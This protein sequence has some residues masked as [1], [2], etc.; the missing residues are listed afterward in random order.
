MIIL[1]RLFI[2]II[3]VICISAS[4]YAEQTEEQKRAQEMAITMTKARAGDAQAQYEV[5]NYYRKGVIPGIFETPDNKEAARWYSKSAFGGSAD[6]MVAYAGCLIQGYLEHNPKEAVKWYEKA[7]KKGNS[8]AYYNLGVCYDKGIGVSTDYTKAFEYFKKAAETGI[9]QAVNSLAICYY[10]G[11]GVAKNTT[12]AFRLFKVSAEGGNPAGFANLGRCYMFGQG[13][14]INPH[15]GV[16]WYEKAA[17]AGYADCQFFLGQLFYKGA[18]E[19]CEGVS[20]NTDYMK[21]AHYLEMAVDNPN[22]PDYAKAET[23]SL[24][25]KCYRLGRGVERDEHKADALNEQAASYGDADAVK[26][27]EWI[28]TGLI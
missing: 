6:G 25:S 27:R 28:N 16:Y 14:D 11:K 8:S 10:H 15:M 13:I 26:I 9:M 19:Y 17:E 20:I 23:Y 5:G 4:A 2:V 12:E 3:T 21:A 1:H 22:T 7:A 24:L 18:T